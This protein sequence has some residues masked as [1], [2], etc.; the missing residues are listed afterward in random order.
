TIYL[1]YC[2]KITDEGLKYLDGVHTIDLTCCNK[3]TDEG[4]K[5]LKDGN[6]NV[7]IKILNLKSAKYLL[8]D[9]VLNYRK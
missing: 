1:G 3:I 9:Y 4:L 6:P 5:Y 2:K 7:K 8:S